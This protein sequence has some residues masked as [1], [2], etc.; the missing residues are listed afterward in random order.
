MLIQVEP[1]GGLAIMWPSIALT[2]LVD[3]LGECWLVLQGK[4]VIRLVI[5]SC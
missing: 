5:P 1:Y 3:P 4:P 2:M